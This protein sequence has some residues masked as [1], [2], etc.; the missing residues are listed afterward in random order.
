MKRL[1][2]A[3]LAASL[4]CNPA[5]AA[6]RP[7]RLTLDV[8]IDGSGHQAKDR[9]HSKFTTTESMHAAF[10]LLGGDPEDT[11]RLDH[12]GNAATMQKQVNEANAR[13][14]SRDQ[15]QAM[16][17]KARAQ[18][19]ACKGDIACMQKIA[20]EMSRATSS[21]NVRPAP[22]GANAGRFIT[23]AAA[24]AGVCKPEYT[25]K[26]RNDVDGVFPD[27]QGLVPFTSNTS[28]DFKAN[29]MQSLPL[30]SA[31]LVVDK[32]ANKIYLSMQHAEVLG[33]VK[34]TE[35]GRVRVNDSNIGVRMNQDAL[36]WV[37]RTLNGAPKSGKE[38]TT[39]KIPTNT[40]LG[41]VGEKI[42]NV[43]MAWKFESK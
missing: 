5:F 38:R 1:S 30:C 4:L 15:Q 18:G 2:I 35:G 33:N 11:N 37:A 28:A 12:D 10:T 34:R 26:I 20:M 14:P 41:G 9:A 43:E 13:A 24:D 22:A 21:W 23:Y 6:D 39:L 19:E 42:I 25:A 7:G 29:N 16:M 32:S 3:A 40:T 27:V 36:E 17:E 8:K 31:M